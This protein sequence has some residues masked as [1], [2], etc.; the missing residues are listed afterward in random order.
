MKKKSELKLDIDHRS[1]AGNIWSGQTA[2]LGQ[3]AGTYQ[4]A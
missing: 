3:R 1:L 4:F 2:A